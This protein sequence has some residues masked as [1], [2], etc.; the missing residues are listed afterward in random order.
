MDGGYLVHDIVSLSQVNSWEKSLLDEPDYQQIQE[1]FVQARHLVPTAADGH[2][3]PPLPTDLLLPI[4]HNA[5]FY[6]HQV[7]EWI[8]TSVII[9]TITRT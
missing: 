7:C 1:G 4:L 3:I 6:L 9:V 8:T 5:L 2:S